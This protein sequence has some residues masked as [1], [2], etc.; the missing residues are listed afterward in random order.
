R[1]S[2]WLDEAISYLT[3][4]FSASDILNNINESPHPP[5][6]YLLLHYWLKVIP[7]SDTAIR[8]LSLL[9]NLLLIPVIYQLTHDLLGRYSLAL[10][11]ALFIA[12]SPFQIAYSHE[13]RMY[14]LLML[15]VTLT[16]WTYWR[17]IHDGKWYW[18]LLFFLSALLAMYTHFFSFFVLAAIGLY[19]LINYRNQRALMMTIVI[20]LL[21]AV[22]FLPWLYIVLGKVEVGTGSLRP[23]RTTENNPIKSIITFTFLMFGHSTN[24]W[25]SGA[26]L[27]LTVAIIVIV[28]IEM[29]R[30]RQEDEAQA[31]RFLVL[32]VLCAIILPIIYYHVRPFFLPE[33]TM[34]AASP[35]LMIL[36]AW[37]VTRRHSPLP[38]LVMAAAFTMFVGSLVYLFSEAQKPPYR[39]AI[40]FVAQNRE[41]GDVVLHTSDGSYLSALRYENLPD[42]VLLAGDPDPRKPVAVYQAFGGDVWE[43]ETAVH[44]GQRLWLIVALEHSVAW[45]QTQSQSI[46][47]E[48]TLVDEQEF[49]GIK[50]YLYDLESG[51]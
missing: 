47:D 49:G 13:L 44:A 14:T 21:L 51:R 19:A 2:L 4:N 12:I 42:H 27:F 17:A 8:S 20:G 41:N 36:L 31:L 38:Y 25:Y 26:A 39:E 50:V 37:A 23:L 30:V 11:A 6:Y 1:D 43:R 22:L 16:A 5:L 40:Q 10:L 35:F 46:A 48:Y 3:A 34:A 29:R 15:L 7:D 33:R 45:Q 28:M 18:W 32:L 9:S 24:L